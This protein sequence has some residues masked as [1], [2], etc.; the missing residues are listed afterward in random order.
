MDRKSFN[1]LILFKKLRNQVRMW[2]EIRFIGGWIQSEI[3]HFWDLI[4]GVVHQIWYIDTIPKVFWTYSLIEASLSFNSKSFNSKLW[5]FNTVVSRISKSWY[6]WTKILR[7]LNLIRLFNLSIFNFFIKKIFSIIQ[8]FPIFFNSHSNF[9][10][11]LWT[12]IKIKSGILVNSGKVF[13]EIVKFLNNK[14][15]IHFQTLSF[16]HH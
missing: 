2:H 14:I 9:C 8:W 3:G 4:F 10:Y 7:Y 16:D 15:R 12:I 1:A 5:Q 13:Y 11:E 6:W